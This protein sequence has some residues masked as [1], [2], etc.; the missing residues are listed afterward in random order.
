M[1]EETFAKEK[2]AQGKRCTENKDGEEEDVRRFT[3]EGETVCKPLG[4]SWEEEGGINPRIKG[5]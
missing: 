2:E 4:E 1:L 3:K 5:F